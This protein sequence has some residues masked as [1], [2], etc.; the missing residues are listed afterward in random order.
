MRRGGR[1]VLLGVLVLAVCAWP[2]RSDEPIRFGWNEEGVAVQVVDQPANRVLEIIGAATGIPVVLDPAN[3]ARLDGLYRKRTLEEL[4]L[5]LAPGVVIVYRYDARLKTEVIDRVFSTSRVAADIKEAQL[6]DLVVSRERLAEGV[7]P[8]PNRPIRYSGIGASVQP[9]SDGAGIF[10]R[11]LSPGSP[12]ARAGIA[13][14]DL[15]IAVDGRAVSDFED[16]GE[17]AAAIRGPDQTDVHL[18]VRFPDGQVR[19]VVVRR[20]VFTWGVIT[21]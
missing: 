11:P 17:I 5:D 19:E 15:V 16:I 3:E 13:L 2:V 9:S 12:A 10:L 1:G 20:E 18:T 14:G 4:L 7:V 6:R 21:Q 8:L